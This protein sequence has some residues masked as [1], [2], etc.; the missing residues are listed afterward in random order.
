MHGP[1][2]DK[3]RS[4]V[5]QRLTSTDGQEKDRSND[6]WGRRS[7]PDFLSSIQVI[8]CIFWPE[9][10]IPIRLFDIFLRG[11]AIILTPYQAGKPTTVGRLIA[12]LMAQDK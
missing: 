10:R 5:N 4:M 7:S 9:R 8:V 3:A 2:A 1:K 12:K 6:R 11:T